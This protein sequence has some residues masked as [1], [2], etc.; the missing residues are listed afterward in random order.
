MHNLFLLLVILCAAEKESTWGRCVR[1]QALLAKNTLFRL[2]KL[3]LTT[4]H[5]RGWWRGFTQYAQ[6]F[7]HDSLRLPW[8]LKREFRHYP[9][10]IPSSSLS[11]QLDKKAGVGLWGYQTILLWVFV[12]Y[13]VIEESWGKDILSSPLSTKWSIRTDDKGGKS[14][15]FGQSTL[16]G[17]THSADYGV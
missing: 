2:N 17:Y 4:C 1:G 5:S 10:F 6:I 11:I 3:S 13:H 14:Q 12:L 16:V 7:F 15:L 9:P 8:T